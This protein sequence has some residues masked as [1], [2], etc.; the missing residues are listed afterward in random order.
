[1]SSESKDKAVRALAFALLGL[2][3]LLVLEH[4]GRRSRVLW[5][6]PSTYMRRLYKCL[7]PYAAWL[8]ALFADV[9]GFLALIDLDEWYQTL[10]E[11]MDPACALV[12]G[13][14]GTWFDGVYRR[15]EQTSSVN[16]FG[17]SLVLIVATIVVGYSVP[18]LILLGTMAVAGCANAAWN[19][20]LALPGKPWDMLAP[21]EEPPQAAAR[22]GRTRSK[23]SR[24][25]SR[26]PTR[27]ANLM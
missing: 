27:G 22:T 19:W 9:V 18:A 21:A 10:Q 14:G 25:R 1:M 16:A 12:F 7:L 4:V 11:F 20:N 6:R 2:L 24:A 23:G 26:T 8:G 13:I 17:W 5:L 3:G 15:V